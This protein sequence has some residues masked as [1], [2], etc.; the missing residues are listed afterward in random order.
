MTV[1]LQRQS[2]R[3]GSRRL[4]GR[5]RGINCA[6]ASS[7]RH[8]ARWMSNMAMVFTG[9]MQDDNYDDDGDGDEDEKGSGAN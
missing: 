4:R 5:R 8:D 3:M 6:F 1:R 2:V 9:M 7:A